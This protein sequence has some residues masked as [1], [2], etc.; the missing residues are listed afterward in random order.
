VANP[1]PL[2]V[3]VGKGITGIF[4]GGAYTKAFYLSNLKMLFELYNHARKAGTAKVE[5]EVDSRKR[6]LF[7]AST[8]IS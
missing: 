4:T 3:R 2:L 7:S 8:R 5:E 6:A 1:L